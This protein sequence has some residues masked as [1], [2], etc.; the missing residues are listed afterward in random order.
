MK[1]TLAA[2]AAYFVIVFALGFALG[3]LRVLVVA[4]RLGTTLAVLLEAP[5]MLAASWPSARWCIRRFGVAGT[6]RARLSMGLAAFALLMI[7]ELAVGMALF[8]RSLGGHLA[9]YLTLDGAL[10]L[11]AQVIF[12]LIPAAQPRAR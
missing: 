9:A 7:A 1:Q 6:L 11:G 12:A 10:G 4:P 3:T 5:V 2:G 8:H